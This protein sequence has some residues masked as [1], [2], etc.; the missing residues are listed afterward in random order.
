MN[1]TTDTFITRDNQA[2]FYYKWSAS[3]KVN[4]KGVVQISHGIGEHA[5]RYQPIAKLLQEQGY[6]VYAND[7]RIHG[8][9]VKSKELMGVYEGQNYFDDAVE[10]MRELTLL[11]KNAHPNKKIILFGHSMGSLLSRKYVTKYGNDLNALILSGTASFMKGIG[12]VGLVSANFIKTFRG[13]N[14]KNKFLKSI[15]FSEFNKN[16]KPNRTE[17]DWISTDEHQVDLFEADPY[18]TADFSLSVFI[19]IIKGSKEINK[20]EAFNATPKKL[21]IYI[22][23]GDKDPVGEMG[24]GIKRVVKQYSKAGI[25]DLTL[26]LYKGG[27]HE[28]L[29][30]TNRGEVEQDVISWL[31]RRIE[32]LN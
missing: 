1:Y 2:I 14:K 4:F 24:K 10:D 16:F 26:K 21:P 8:Q 30:E 28:M 32:T 19:D 6:E 12:N 22:F 23:S 15:S 31:N 5:G 17:L 3:S 9:S 13:R 18:R 7:H 27:R 25:N 29:N 20:Q 11:I